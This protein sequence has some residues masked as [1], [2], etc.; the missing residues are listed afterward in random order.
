MIITFSSFNVY[1]LQSCVESNECLFE[2]YTLESEIDPWNKCS[3]PWI[4]KKNN[5]HNPLNKSSPPK[6][7]DNLN[8]SYTV[9][10]RDTRPQAARTS[11]V[12]VFE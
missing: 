10:P 7:T 12:H 5:K 2:L 8:I 4:S 1:I 3:R 9:R 11:T 6:I